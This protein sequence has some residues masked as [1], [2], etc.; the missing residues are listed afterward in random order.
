MCG[1]C[2][3]FGKN[4]ANYPLPIHKLKHRGPDDT[5]YIING[6]YKFGHTRLSIID[7][8][9]GHQPMYNPEGTLCIVFNGEIYNYRL[10]R[11]GLRENH[12]FKTNSDTE[13]ILHLFEEEGPMGLAKLDGMFALAIASPQGLVMARDP[14]GIKPLYYQE[15]YNNLYFASEIKAFI[16][17]QTPITEFPP[18]HI[19]TTDGGYQ[20]YFEIPRDYET[21]I[22]WEESLRVLQHKL[23]QAVQKRLMS[24]VPLGSFLSGGL[25]SC[26]ITALIKQDMDELHTFSVSME[27]SNDR[28][29]ALLAAKYLGTIHHEYIL[30][31]GEIW[32]KLPEIIYYL[33]S[34]DQSLV[35][36]AVANYFLAKMAAEEVKVVLTGEGADELFAGYAYL[37]RFSNEEEL[38]R[39]LWEIT[40]ALHNTNLQRVDRMTMAHGLEAR[41]PFLD[42]EMITWAMKL[43]PAYKRNAAEGVSKWC[44][45]EAFR[46]E[47]LLPEEI[48]LRKKEKFAEGSGVA[49]ILAAMATEKV[50][51][52]SYQAELSRG[53]PLRSREEYYYFQIFEAYFGREQAMNLVGRSKS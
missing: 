53:T 16:K 30:S 2:G 11:K 40:S 31:P 39:E 37:D 5:G 42:R 34:F 7:L 10:L 47:S 6:H 48:I 51:E 44:L 43:P 15:V 49:G 46:K 33:E 12:T 1:I 29:Y 19:Y 9:G 20:A 13:V 18:G 27:Q 22:K 26:L 24:D 8:A 52:G 21:N 41:V 23:K 14:V 28:D 50:S 45:R 38:H 3:Y 17:S 32:D 4:V 35:R 25:D 36:S